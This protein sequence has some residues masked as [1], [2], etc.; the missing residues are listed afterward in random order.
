MFIRCDIVIKLK[1]RSVKKR[2]LRDNLFI[3]IKIR[4][5]IKYTVK[6]WI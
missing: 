2:K 5:I 6:Y 3:V 4:L 1:N